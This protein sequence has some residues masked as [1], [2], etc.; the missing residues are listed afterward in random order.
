MVY[1]PKIKRLVRS[2]ASA[3]TVQIRLVIGRLQ[4]FIDIKH[5]RSS[6][7]RGGDL[8]SLPDRKELS[9]VTVNE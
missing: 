1:G 6:S 8:S 4:G 3:P 2:L 5:H 7:P 9:I